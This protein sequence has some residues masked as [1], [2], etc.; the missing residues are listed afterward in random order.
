MP[1]RVAS[2]E[3][4]TKIFEFAEDR[5][6]LGLWVW[7]YNSRR[8]QWSRGIFRLL[9]IDY[10]AVEPS[11]DQIR[12][13]VHPDDALD[14]TNLVDSIDNHFSVSRE[15]R[16]ILDDKRVKWLNV[17]SEMVSSA[18]G[19][20]QMVGYLVD[21]TSRKEKELGLATLQARTSTLQRDVAVCFWT[22]SRD[23]LRVNLPLWE[24][25]TGQGAAEAQQ[26]GWL[27]CVHPEDRSQVESTRRRSIESGQPY[28]ATYRLRLRD[29]SYAEVSAR[30]SLVMNELHKMPEWTGLLISGSG[31]TKSASPIDISGKELRAA[32]ALL[33]WTAADLAQASG[34]SISSIRRIED[35]DG[36]T[37]TRESTLGKILAALS[38]AGVDFVSEGDRN[39]VIR[40]RISRSP[41]V[42][43]ENTR[44]LLE[45]K[46]KS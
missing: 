13:R 40:L 15:F 44:D 41:N 36:I 4:R 17:Y 20:P 21:V 9:Q 27:A 18:D 23:G 3:P 19:E 34:T 26:F 16:V 32:R 12:S 30:A 31:L 7:D 35:Y 33:N 25:W 43:A 46:T 42:S 45:D 14:F 1:F 6:G 11:V 8:M 38:K 5:L 24:Q 29:G 10:G 37:Q 2:K 22:A 28:I 39:E